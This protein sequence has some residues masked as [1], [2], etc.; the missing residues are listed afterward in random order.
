M[1]KYQSKGNKAGDVEAVRGYADADWVLGDGFAI[2]I[3][4]A[5]WTWTEDYFERRRV[6]AERH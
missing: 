3:L 2:E 6:A 5:V 4:E 1:S